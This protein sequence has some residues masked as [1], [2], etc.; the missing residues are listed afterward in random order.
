M[1][2]A[3]ICRYATTPADLTALALGTLIVSADGRPLR[4][5]A[6]CIGQPYWLDRC[7]GC[8]D[9]TL[10]G[11]AHTYA[12]DQLFTEQGDRELAR[13][14]CGAPA[15]PA[16]PYDATSARPHLPGPFLIAH[17]PQTH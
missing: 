13:V 10:V 8:T 15:E 17:T 11:H 3:R 9:W 7:P 14:A 2:E 1:S 6:K 4:R 5:T 16:G 12:P